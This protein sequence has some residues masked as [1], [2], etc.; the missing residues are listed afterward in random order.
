MP[1]ER[2]GY[3]LRK[4]IYA[5]CCILVGVCVLST[6]VSWLNQGRLYENFAVYEASEQTSSSVRE[7]DR[8]VQELKAHSEK[9]LQT[10]AVSQLD[11]SQTIQ[12]S[13][14]T[15]IDEVID[16]NETG[17]IPNTLKRMR[18]SLMTF[19]KQLGQAAKQRALATELVQHN[20]PQR[21]ANFHR[22]VNELQV[23]LANQ[24]EPESDFL[25]GDLVVDGVQAY[26]K[27]RQS[28]QQ[29]FINPQSSDFD[30]AVRSVAEA[31]DLFEQIVKRARSLEVRGIQER[32]DAEL[33]EFLNRGS[34]AFQATRSYMFYSNV[35]MAGEISEFTYLSD[36][37]KTS[38]ES[39][40]DENRKERE[41][42][43]KKS[44][45]ISLMISVAAITLAIALAARLSMMIIS[46]IASITQTFQGLSRGETIEEIPALHRND[47][48]GRMAQAAKVFSDKN[49][50]TRLLLADS[51]RL[52]GELAKKA[53]DLE[54]VN[55]ELDN[56]AY[57]ASH[58]LK[59]PLRGI[60]HLATWVQEDCEEVL[61]D[62]SRQHLSL[63]LHRVGKMEALLNDLLSYS[64]VGRIEQATE[65][66]DLGNMLASIVSILDLPKGFQVLPVKRLPIVKVLR[67]PLQQVLMNLI[68]NAVKY[69]DKGGEGRIEVDANV[70]DGI[71]RFSI[72]DNG[73]G[74]A[75]EYHAKIFE[76]Y[77][78]VT[79]AQDGSGMGL[80]I[81]KKQVSNVGG[82]IHV[83]SEE[84]EGATFVFTWPATEVPRPVPA[85]S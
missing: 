18:E 31:R 17:E 72:Q 20:L 34:L 70:S 12:E 75:P 55:E 54:V 15:Q 79:N 74:I 26:L 78:R 59:S 32:L 24:T 85:I 64:R 5:T 28:L 33:A 16:H 76:M 43:R 47:E 23:E 84:G 49:E 11:A 36:R 13:L 25:V 9:Y 50:Q 45:T 83:E 40:R 56:F 68:S 73:I 39:R 51:E 2:V 30:A 29:Y 41:N 1:F 61:P 6:L 60:A 52:R 42:A 81:A 48:I 10:G 35:V 67:T 62:D 71:C 58:D 38:V 63:M 57:V 77:Q 3:S 69:N 37:L 66:V 80:A 65:V 4:Q 22:L 14:I 7:I 44:Q 82:K 46:P 21:D 27:G 19:Q 8:D 53:C